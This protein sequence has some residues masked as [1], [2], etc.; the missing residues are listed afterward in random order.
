VST[1]QKIIEGLPNTSGALESF[2]GHRNEDTPRNN[3]FIGSVYRTAEHM[4]H[5]IAAWSMQVRHNFNQATHNAVV[6]AASIGEEEMREEFAFYH[7]MPE[8]AL[9]A[10]RVLS[11]R[12]FT[13]TSPVVTDTALSKIAQCVLRWIHLLHSLHFL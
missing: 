2:N 3:T 4:D 13:L 8:R 11:W 10:R 9:A 7:T 5:S 6:L 1:L 12:C